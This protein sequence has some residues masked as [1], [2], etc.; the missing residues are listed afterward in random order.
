[1]VDYKYKNLYWK[2]H[3]D[4][5][6]KIITDDGNITFA[7]KD[8]NWEYFELTESLCCEQQLKFGL[9]ESSVLKFK[10]SNSFIPLTGKWLTVTETL[11]KNTDEPF[12]YGRYKVFSDVPTA[13]KRYRDITAYDAMYDILETDVTQWYNN[14]LPNVNTK[15]TLKQFRTNFISYFHLQQQDVTLVNDNMVIER[16]LEPEQISGKDVITAICEI[17]GCFGHIGRDGKFHY[18]YLP[19]NIQGLYPS[20]TLY[21]DHAPKWLI[22]SETGH[23]YPQDP[24]STKLGDGVYISCK[25]EDFLCKKIDKI[26]IKQQEDDI[27]YIYGE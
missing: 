24:K 9:C 7:N 14:I 21:P 3:I 4:K 22:Q 23:L 17:N 5:Q 2:P 19:Q 13:D 1:M 6:L 8:I 27:G 20:N 11:N 18:I 16:T 25:Y 12:C 26:Q 15:L 10:I